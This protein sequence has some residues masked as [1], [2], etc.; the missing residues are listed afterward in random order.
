M[1]KRLTRSGLLPLCW[2]LLMNIL[3]LLP[4]RKLESNTLIKVP[5]LDKIVHF[6]LYG[7]L[8]FLVINWLRTRRYT[9]SPLVVVLLAILHGLFIE[10]LQLL[11]VIN[12]EFSWYDLVFDAGGAIAGCIS[13][14]W[15][16]TP[17]RKNLL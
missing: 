8:V 11:P 15:L 2:F 1:L 13:S 14:V 4:V 16:K 7:I 3:F 17:A 12:R 9:L 6:G 5:N 10:Y